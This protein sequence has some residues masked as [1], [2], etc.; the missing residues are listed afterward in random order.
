MRT[1]SIATPASDAWRKPIVVWAAGAA[2]VFFQ[3][4]IQ[5][6]SG[7]IVNGLMHSFALTALGGGFLASAYYYIYVSLQIPAGILMDRF[8]PRKLLSLGALILSVGAMLFAISHYLV[9]AI[10]GRL[11]MGGGAAFAFVG[12]LYLISRW[13]VPSYF[14]LM[15]AAV[16]AVGMIGCL[17]GSITL[18]ELVSRVGWRDCMFGVA[19]ISAVLAIVIWVVV[20]DRPADYPRQKVPT[21]QRL[22]KNL[23]DIVRQRHAWVN[24][25]YSGMMFSVVT[26]FVAL[27]AVPFLQVEHHITLVGSALLANVMFLGVAVGGPIIGYL[28]SKIQ[29]RR[30]L[31]C[32]ASVVSAILMALVI[33]IPSLPIA[34]VACLMFLLGMSACSYVLTFVI[35]NEIATPRSRA[36]CV[37]FVNTL[38]VVTAPILQPLLGYFLYLASHG[39]ATTHYS[40][41]E[42]QI[43][44]SAMPVV[45]LLAAVLAWYLPKR[46]QI[47][48]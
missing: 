19:L 15:T 32:L 10:I 36:T 27:W 38:C 40:I 17:I 39:A 18:A 2:F 9:I 13:F 5:L 34:I 22:W 4:L 7:E 1:T 46:R 8:G 21:N 44:L 42:Y 47:L 6:T 12:C 45:S 43:S 24:G 31:M 14:A 33:Y 30:L 48:R 35:A 37:G 23:R 29:S 3:F 41:Y 11:L 28:D 25:L 26:V 20:R 16:E